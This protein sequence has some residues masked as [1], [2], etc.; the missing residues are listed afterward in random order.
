[1]REITY[2]EAVNEAIKEEMRKD[3][4]IVAYGED[5][6]E[7]GGD[8]QCTVGVLEEFGPERVKNTPISEAVIAGASIGMAAAGLRPLAEISYDDFLF[9]AGDQI[10]N[11]MA[12]LRYMTGGQLKLPITLRTTMGGGPSA[13]AQ[14]AQT[15]YGMFMNVPGLKIVCPGTPYDAKGILKS[16]IRDNN[17]VLVF[18][19]VFLYDDKGEVPEEE[20]YVPIGK[21]DV[22]REGKDITLVALSL[23]VS[24][25]LNV[26]KKMEEKGIDVEVVDP[27]SLAPLDTETIIN[28]VKKTGRVV[29]AS[30]GP[31]TNGAG[32]EISAMISEQAFEYLESPIYRVAEKDCPIPFSPVL[33]NYVLP[34]EEDIIEAIERI[35]SL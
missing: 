6:A 8:Y 11:Q 3:D 29:I 32:A 15:V 21:A 10:V 1:M 25:S 27:I 13:A 22:K 9:I 19:H 28:S 18:E 35:M 17:P 12:K 20:Y 2:R 5:I 24:K 23:M 34:Q 14:H 30:N 33:E 31:K 4:K 16:A 26:A 7:F